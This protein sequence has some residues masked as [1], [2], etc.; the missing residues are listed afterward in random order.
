MA[1]LPSW[2]DHEEYSPENK[3][4]DIM[5]RTQAPWILTQV[6][7]D[8]R[9][10]ALSAPRL[11]SKIVIRPDLAHSELDLKNTLLSL[12]ISL[13]RSANSPLF[14]SLQ[15]S[16][17]THT[18][19]HWQF[20]KSWT[21]IL[22]AL[23]RRA[24]HWHEVSFSM[25]LFYVMQL[26]EVKGRIPLLRRLRLHIWPKDYVRFGEL[27]IFA[28]SPALRHLQ[29]RG[30]RTV[31]PLIPWSQLTR[32]AADGISSSQLQLTLLCQMPSVAHAS[33]DFPISVGPTPSLSP[34]TPNH[35]HTMIL[36]GD[37]YFLDAL[38]LPALHSLSLRNVLDLNPAISLINRS[39]C[40][41]TN[42]ALEPRGKKV[43]DSDITAIF[44]VTPALTSLCLC[45][46]REGIMEGVLV[47]LTIN[48]DNPEPC[49]LPNLQKLHFQSHHITPRQGDLLFNM[50]KSRWKRGTF[51]P[52]HSIRSVRIP[53]NMKPSIVD[54][55][56]EEGLDICASYG[57]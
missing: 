4:P 9:S 40:S 1:C 56:R 8:W 51:A 55:L 11:W 18:M 2:W 33:F 15:A 39:S 53:A 30:N 7:R 13:L 21:D 36:T 29:L 19:D 45:D 12:E 34:L 23:M 37:P 14:V 35:L 43:K 3:Y 52:V 48:E 10:I 57:Y 26:V 22:G 42:L 32:Y 16:D 49:L 5:D 38:T 46:W 50:I 47:R 28:Q 31:E 27:D 25:D 54:A 20:K 41:L 17:Y 24:E 44:D 6:C